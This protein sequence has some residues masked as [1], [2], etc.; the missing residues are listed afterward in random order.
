MVKIP[1]CMSTQHPDNVHLPFFAEEAE[2][3]GDDEIKEAYYAFSH[4]GC[5]EQMWDCEGKEVDNFVIKKLATKYE[6]FFKKKRLGKDLFITL[7]ALN[8][9]YE[10]A[11]AK[12]LLETLDSIPRSFDA[13]KLFYGD[14]CAPIFELIIPMVNSHKDIDRVYSY[15]SDFVVAKQ[16]KVIRR[17]DIKIAKWIGRFKPEKINVIP[18]FEDKDGLLNAH[19]ITRKYL[20]DKDLPYQRVFLARPD[21]AMNYGL[22]SAVLLNKIA[23]LRLGD[24]SQEIGVEIYPIIGVGSAPFRGHLK[25]DTVDDVAAEYPSTQTFSIQSAFKYDNP[26][27]KVIAAIDKLKRRQRELPQKIDVKRATKLIERYAKAYQ[28]QVVKLIPVVNQVAKYVPGR[29]K[30]KLHVGL[31]GYSRDVQGESLPRAIKFT[32]ALYSLGMPPELF[33]LNAL[34]NDDLKFLKDAYINF[35]G[36]MRAALRFFNPRTC[37]LPTGLKKKIKSLK[38]DYEISK[39][40]K[41]IT[42]DIIASLKE[43]RT[44]YLQ[45]YILRAADLRRFLG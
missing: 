44:E 6:T 12:M 38:I 27:K 35:E 5:D 8:P 41:D 42:D 20:R 29:R 7:R 45:E 16:N 34:K 26:P 30:R 39:E 24:L 10:R 13:S 9:S 37:Y 2:L 22:V 17:G 4:L 23:L 21:P 40:H 14:D 15:Y 19:N 32:A 18:L 43:N 1:K 31:F 25:P 28:A 11:E 36:D 3:G 33:A